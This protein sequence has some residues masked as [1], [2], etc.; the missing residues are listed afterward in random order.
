MITS[1][2]PRF[3]PYLS[4]P[5]PA[6]PAQ[7][8]PAPAPAPPA[9]PPKHDITVG[10]AASALGSAVVVAGIE[11]V[12]NTASSLMHG[13]NHL[14]HAYKTLWKT[15][16]IGPVLKTSIG[17]LLPVAAVA[18]PVLTCVGSIGFGLF[19][20]FSASLDGGFG[21]AVK[22]GCEDVKY[23][24]KDVEGSLV[25]TLQ[26]WE[27]EKLPAGQKPFDIR[28][29]DGAKG[30]IGGVADGAVDG[31]GIG[32]ITL[33]RT[34]QGVVKAYK[35]IWKDNSQ[36]PV[37]K[38]TESLLVPLAAVVATPLA[39]V[40]GAVYGLATGF[41]KGYSEGLGASLEQG[42]K[43]VKDFNHLVSEAFK[44]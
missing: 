22:K 21:N 19:R 1:A 9:N 24:H 38:T 26:E 8:A 28:V 37:L 44:D 33:A 31:L 10:Q 18:S 40:V 14:Y 32:L 25:K 2:L 13:G 17:L 35:D 3:N 6:A 16:M 41:Q 15:E 27:T 23:F 4:T 5:A 30:L 12:G 39:T 11:G 43:N 20:G 36:G 34:P 42:G 7:P 29:V